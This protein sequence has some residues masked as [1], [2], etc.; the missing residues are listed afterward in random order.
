MTTTT[1]LAHYSRVHATGNAWACILR[2]VEG[3]QEEGKE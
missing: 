1:I 2:W 3:G